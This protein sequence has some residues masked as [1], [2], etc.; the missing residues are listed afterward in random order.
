VVEGSADVAGC[1]PDELVSA[2]QRG[3]DLVVIGGIINRPVSSVVARAGLASLA[4]LRGARIGVNQTQGSVSMVLRALL[5]RA[6]LEPDDYRQVEV[7]TT[8]AMADALR[9]NEVDAAMLTAPFDLA[10]LREGFVSLANV[11]DRF[12]NYA[13]T[14]VNARRDWV[15]AHEEL[16]A[17][18]FRATRAAGD[19]LADPSQ[20][21]ASSY[22]LAAGTGM[23]GDTLEHSYEV[24]QQIGVLSRHGEVDPSGLRAVMEL[25]AAEG[26]LVEPV[27]KAEELLLPRWA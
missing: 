11:G 1:S 16:V 10:L 27:P 25:M 24:Y 14:T 6:G 8:P 19:M 12:P 17:A 23:M 13:F 22:A 21:R 2:V 15:Q 26:L 20:R 4:E 5:R 3:H 18:F 7:G 9:R